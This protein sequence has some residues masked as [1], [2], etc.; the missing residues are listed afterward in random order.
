MPFLF[1][2]KITLFLF[3]L[4]KIMIDSMYPRYLLYVSVVSGVSG[5]LYFDSSKTC[6]KK[7]E[8]QLKLSDMPYTI[9]YEHR[10]IKLHNKNKKKSK[11]F[12]NEI[13]FHFKLAKNRIKIGNYGSKLSNTC[14]LQYTSN[15]QCVLHTWAS[16][17]KF[18]R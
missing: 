16:L 13:L 12:K 11:I 1:S 7:Q 15:T 2:Y 9:A 6:I 18:L 5:P 17:F 4:K 10:F 8:Q 3:S 14:R